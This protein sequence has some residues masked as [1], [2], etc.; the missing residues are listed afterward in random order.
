MASWEDGTGIDL[1][2]E[3]GDSA[4]ADCIIEYDLE[5]VYKHNVET[6]YTNDDGTPG[7]KRI[8]IYP[9]NTLSPIDRKGRMIFAHEFGHVLQLLHSHD[10]GHLMVGG[11]APL[12]SQP[13]EDELRLITILYRLPVI[14]DA[15]DIIKE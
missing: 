14:F 10:L 2:I 4:S 13:T 6:L 5:N 11:T 9:E 8:W 12:V 7:K 15:A 3:T 1:F